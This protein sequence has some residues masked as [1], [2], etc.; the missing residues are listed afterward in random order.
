MIPIFDIQKAIYDALKNDVDFNDK[1]AGYFGEAFSYNI[2]KSE[3]TQNDIYPM[4][5]IH[6]NFAS[7]TREGELYA[8]QFNLLTMLGGYVNDRY[9]N[10]VMTEDLAYDAVKIADDAVC[11]LGLKRITTNHFLAAP[12]DGSDDIEWVVNLGY[13]RTNEMNFI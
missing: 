5:I 13:E 2:D 4:F 9:P 3:V 11:G 8:I 7:Q 6:K 1:C 10:I 12:I